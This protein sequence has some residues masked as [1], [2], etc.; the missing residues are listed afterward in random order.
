MRA[1]PPIF[2]PGATVKSSADRPPRIGI[3]PGK[4]QSGAAIRDRFHGELHERRHGDRAQDI[5]LF[6]VGGL[7]SGCTLRVTIL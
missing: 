7:K 4:D 2:I 5:R 3:Q 6:A 1:I